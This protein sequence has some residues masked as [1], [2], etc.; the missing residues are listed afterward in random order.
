MCKRK[1]IPKDH[2]LKIAKLI[3]TLFLCM[4]MKLCILLSILNMKSDPVFLA[5]FINTQNI[6]GLGM[7]INSSDF[8]IFKD[9]L[10]ITYH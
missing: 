8:V 4:I 5:T 2:R 10:K 1:V 7:A 3:S 6:L 9:F